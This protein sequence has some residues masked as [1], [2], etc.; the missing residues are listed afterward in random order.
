[1]A[2]FFSD[3]FEID[4]DT[5]EAHGAFNIS[6]INDLPLF[7]DPFLLFNSSDKEHR[8]LHDGII[9]YLVFLRD[10]ASIS[11]SDGGLLKAWYC[12]SEVKQNWLGFSVSG[13]SGSGLG[14]EF[15]RALCANLNKIFTDFGT[16]TIT[17]S[18]HLEKVCLI[19]DGVGRDNISDFTTNLILDYLCKYT[20]RFALTHLDEAQ[21]REVAI[22]R[23]AF[24]YETESWET[25]R[26]KLPWLNNDYVLLTPLTILTRD[27]NWIN[28]DDLITRFERVPTAIPDAQLRAE[29]SNY[30]HNAIIRRKDRQPSRQELSDAAAATLLKYPILIDYYIWLKEQ[31]GDEA[32]SESS[33]KVLLAKFFFNLQLKAF[34][35]TL[36]D[37][38]SF[39][40]VGRD[41]YEET[42]TRLVYLKDVIENKGGH[43][44]FY[45]AG[46]PV[47]REKDLQI[48]FRLVWFG[49]PSDVGTEAN[50]GRGPVDF[51]ISRGAPD[52]TLVEMKL[53]KNSQLERNLQKQVEIYKKASDATKGIKVII[54]FTES[55]HDRVIG[56]LD[57]LK[58]LNNKDVI[59][60]DARSDNKPSGSHA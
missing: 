37:Q 33:E 1:L 38:S 34:Q 44:I 26:Y 23:A 15:A 40:S 25:R 19:S 17:K 18:S 55:E 46:K 39:Y 57:K 11:K 14:M 8:A 22:R 54:Y 43:R 29:V 32:T 36:H 5:L 59:L 41:T 52:K 20:E 4:E 45:N 2:T 16:E 28:R 58:L 6:L 21:W 56:I 30:F 53:A 9:N 12:F 7:I 24:N 27:E 3:F 42:H 48:L 50:D 10:R 31:S 49:S 35:K 13:N 60:I 51:K 47:E